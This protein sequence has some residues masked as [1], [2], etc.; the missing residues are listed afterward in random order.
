VIHAFKTNDLF[1]AGEGPRQAQTVDDR[2]GARVAQT[3]LID[4][5][6]RR[7]DLL[8][9]RGFLRC[10]EGKHGAAILD[11]LDDRGGY[12]RRTMTENHRS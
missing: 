2:F 5:R 6:H 8:R 1:P 7:D 10:G 4:A 3:H 11:L 12:F 9:Q